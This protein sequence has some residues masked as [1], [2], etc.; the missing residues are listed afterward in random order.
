MKIFKYKFSKLITALIC[1]ALALCA[2]GFGINLFLC[3]K[4]GIKEAADPVYPILQY[5]LMFFITITLFV[6]LVSILKS[7]YY[8]VEGKT[9]K[10]CFGF[11]KSKYE[12]DKIEKI[13]LDRQTNK[14]SVEFDDNTFIVIVVKEE[15][16][17]DFVQ[18]IIDV[19]PAIEYEIKSKE[20][21]GTLKK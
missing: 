7:S 18:A 1:L 12:I 6:I 17:N 4:N 2:V 10:T 15:W 11:I 3:I 14:L 16:Y 9:F 21:D 20:N 8:C 5:T 13:T 19:K